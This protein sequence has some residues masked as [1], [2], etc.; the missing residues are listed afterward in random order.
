VAQRQLDLLERLPPAQASLAGAPQVVGPE[1]R[2]H[3]LGEPLHN[4]KRFAG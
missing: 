3:C 4:Q 2:A 1:R